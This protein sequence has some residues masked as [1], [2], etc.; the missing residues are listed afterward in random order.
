MILVLYTFFSEI[1]E[2]DLVFE[3]LL[4]QLP[5]KFRSSALKYK[6]CENRW[7]FLL[8]KLL[9]QKGFAELGVADT[10]SLSDLEYTMYNKPFIPMA[11]VDF[12]IA[13]SG[14]CVI[15]AMSTSCRVGI[16]I[17]F[18]NPIDIEAYYNVMIDEERINIQQ[19]NANE[20]L[21]EF[22]RYWTAKESVIKADGKGLSIPLKSFLIKDNQVRLDKTRWFIKEIPISENYICNLATDNREEELKISLVKVKLENHTIVKDCKL[23]CLTFE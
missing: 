14:H 13:H 2:D 10:Y 12:N 6:K 19:S 7:A 4:F 20:K 15:C 22:Y 21:N 5:E 23:N 1:I 18:I 17:E 3:H 8:G 11:A 9:I 16:D